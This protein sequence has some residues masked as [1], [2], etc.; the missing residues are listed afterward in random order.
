VIQIENSLATSPLDREFLDHHTGLAGRTAS[1]RRRL[2]GK[3]PS[4][5]Y[6]LKYAPSPA[7]I[8]ES[9]AAGLT[10]AGGWRR[11]SVDGETKETNLKD[12]QPVSLDS[13]K[14]RRTLTAGGKSYDYYSL[15]VAEE[16]GLEGIS[17]LPF[18][19]KV[20]LENLLRHEDGRT[21]TRTDIEGVAAWLSDKG[22]AGRRSASARPAC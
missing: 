3:L 4:P 15:P 18:S 11:M 5:A 19:M 9:P 2:R 13:F 17:K 10:F 20:L 7:A 12:V 6:Q 22:K 16:N 1:T 14:C 8:G 21:V